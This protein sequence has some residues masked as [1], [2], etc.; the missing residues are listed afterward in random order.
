MTDDSVSRGEDTPQQAARVLARTAAV[1]I[2][3]HDS[4]DGDTIGSALALGRMLQSLGKAVT[5]AGTDPVPVCYEFLPGAG[6]FTSTPRG[7]WDCVVFIDCADRERTT[8]PI[9]AV[10]VTI[11]IDH[12]PT[13][14]RYAGINLIDPKASAVGEQIFDLAAEFGLK[15]DSD[16]ATCLYTAIATDTGSFQFA[17]TTA[18]TFAIAAELVRAGANPLVV[19]EHAFGARSRRHLELLSRALSGLTLSQDEKVAWMTLTEGD[20]SAAG[21]VEQDADGIVNYARMIKGVLIGLLFREVRPGVI[22]VGLRGRPGVDV[23][24]VA[25]M[26]RGGGHAGAAGATIEGALGDVIEKVVAASIQEA[27]ERQ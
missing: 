3:T 20:M 27:G 26:F 5:I 7:D 16:M 8:V 19:A 1:L 12:H 11:N 17:N 2:V 18:R 4:P 24:S 10:P 6:Q 25:A 15:I 22:R 14:T 13:N 9:P 23:S 21:A